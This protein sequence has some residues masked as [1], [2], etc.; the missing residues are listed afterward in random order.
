ML[1]IA[2]ISYTGLFSSNFARFQ[3]IEVSPGKQQKEEKGKSG[4]S[5]SWDQLAPFRE[6]F[7]PSPSLMA[8]T[9][10]L[11]HAAPLP[12]AGR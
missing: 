12:E 7:R 9:E 2:K 6:A 11:P 3:G 4:C 1:Q 5:C 10:L 8:Q